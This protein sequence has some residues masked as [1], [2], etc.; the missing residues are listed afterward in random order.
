MSKTVR[1]TEK[2]VFVV[3]C[4]NELL[5]ASGPCAVCFTKE[6]AEKAMEKLE[7][8]SSDSRIDEVRIWED[9]NE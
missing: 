4:R 7:W 5:N 3:V 9:V 2:V 8:L 6:A 1:K